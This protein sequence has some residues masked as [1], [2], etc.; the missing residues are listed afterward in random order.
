MGLKMTGQ[1]H[2]DLILVRINRVCAAALVECLYD[3]KK[4]PRKRRSS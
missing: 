2:I 1:F 4:S 3:L